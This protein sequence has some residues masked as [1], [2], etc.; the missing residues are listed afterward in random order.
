MTT[1]PFDT[2]QFA[3]ELVQNG[4][5]ENYA[6]AIT[7]AF[8][9]AQQESNAAVV[10]QIKHDYNLDN[11]ATQRDLKELELNLIVKMAEFKSE[12]VKEITKWVAAMIIGQ[13]GVVFG[14]LKLLGKF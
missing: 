10:E 4:V 1:I 11:L 7:K 9:K 5:P 3:E 8:T 12:T 13:M 2:M 14:I 6:K